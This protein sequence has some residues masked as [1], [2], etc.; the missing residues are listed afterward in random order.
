[1][2]FQNIV[3]AVGKVASKEYI[4]EWNRLRRTYGSGSD[5]L[6]AL[7][8]KYLAHLVLNQEDTFTKPFEILSNNLSKFCLNFSD[9]SGRR[10]TNI[11]YI[12]LFQ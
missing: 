11:T 9:L 8:E 2:F 6:L 4:S 12:I 3:A 1:M 7:V 10:Q 5:S